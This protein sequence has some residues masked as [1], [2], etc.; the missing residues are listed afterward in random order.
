MYYEYLNKHHTAQKMKFSNNN[1]FRKCDQLLG[2]F[3]EEILNP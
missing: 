1:F 2:I 3:T